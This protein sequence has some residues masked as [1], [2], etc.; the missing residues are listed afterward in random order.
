MSHVPVFQKSNQLPK[1][2]EMHEVSHR[3]SG[4]N[5]TRKDM[6]T[7]GSFGLKTRSSLRRRR[8]QTRIPPLSSRRPPASAHR[9]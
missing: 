9:D 8:S 6:S 5:P 1:S 7:T 3:P 4:L 2:E